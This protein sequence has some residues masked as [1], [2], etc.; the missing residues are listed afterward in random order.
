MRNQFN[1]Q[2][3]ALNADLIAM[4]A[5]CEG[6]I[7]CAVKALTSGDSRLAET[8]VEKSRAID[9]CEREIEATCLRLIL[10]Q[11]PVARDLR[12][13]T[14]ALKIIT[15]M[16][17]IGN[18]A[19]DIAELCATYG[20]S[21]DSG[22]AIAEMATAVIRMVTNAVD[23]FVRRDEVLAGEVVTSDDVADGLF[24]RVKTELCTLIAEDRTRGEAALDT[25]LIAK[26]LERIGDHAVNIALWVIFAVTGKHEGDNA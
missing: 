22:D 5:L 20:V 6:A 11:Q 17:R 9:R 2:L 23:A 16:E 21:A 14:V 26:Y 4:G 8:A 18:Q 1:E 10:Q 15:D 7:A 19:A 3:N 25:L 24:V 12:Q 13:I